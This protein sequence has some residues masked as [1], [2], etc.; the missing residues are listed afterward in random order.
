MEFA[1]AWAADAQPQTDL[2]LSTF[3]HPYIVS[4]LGVELMPG[5]LSMVMEFKEGVQTLDRLQ[6]SHGGR[7]PQSVARTLFQQL[8]LALEFCHLRGLSNRDCKITDLLVHVDPGSGDATLQL[9][10]FSFA[11]DSDKDADSNPMAQHGSVLFAAPEVI[12]ASSAARYS[13]CSADVWSAGVVLCTLLFGCHPHLGQEDLDQAPGDQILV[14]MTNAA[15]GAIMVPPEEAAAQPEAFA[16]MVSMLQ[17]DPS[18]R[19]TASQ[20]LSHPWMRAGLAGELGQL[21][22]ALLA[23]TRLAAESEARG[24]AVRERVTALLD[25]LLGSRPGGSAP[26]ARQGARG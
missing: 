1:T 7:L 12:T 21:N 26:G 22:A 8:M 10:D 2:D 11:K 25:S 9:T 14:I 17:V 20:V 5:G 24:R 15:R 3:C 6:E 16:L 4:T 23:D 13:G 19:P 18:R